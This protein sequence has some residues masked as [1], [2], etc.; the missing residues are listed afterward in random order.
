ME[1]LLPIT[2]FP[3]YFASKEG[4]IYSAWTNNGIKEGKRHKISPRKWKNGYVGLQ[5]RVA[6]QTYLNTSIHRLICIAFHGVPLLGQEVSHINGKRDD[7]RAN[8]LMW[9]SR[10]D[11]H[12]RKIAHG[13]TDRGSKNSRAS[14]THE[15]VKVIKRM[16]VNKQYTHQE[17]ATQ[18]GVSRGTIS[19]INNGSRYKYE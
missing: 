7:N 18:Y 2:G 12:K 10:S 15:Q 4:N 5:V 9:E 3:G 14:L 19:K 1:Q 6:N 8:N 11:N 17:I 13:T 16:L